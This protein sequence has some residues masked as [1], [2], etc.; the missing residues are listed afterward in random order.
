VNEQSGEV[1][2]EAIK[3]I[4]TVASLHRQQHFEDR[5]Y[6]ATERPHQ[7]ARRKAITASLGYGL[8][9]GINIY[10]NAVAFYG[11][12]RLMDDCKVNFLQMFTAMMVIMMTSQAVGRASVFTSI[13]A[14]AKTSAIT[15]FELMDR[16]PLIDPELE[17][18]EPSTINGNFDFENVTFRYPARPDVP[19]F[20]GEFNMHGQ[21]NTTIALVGKILKKALQ[22]DI[23]IL[24]YF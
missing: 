1:A 24:I 22:V 5:F 23:L 6:K 15:I 16:T 20:N 3:E 7:L 18:I 10:T 19:I 21:S 17:G 11:G 12:M 8:Q 2:G 4:R 14:K 9:Q 13:F